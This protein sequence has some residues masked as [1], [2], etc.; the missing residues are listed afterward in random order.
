MDTDLFLQR[1]RDLPLEEGKALV[2]EYVQ[3]PQD[4]QA[5]GALLGSDALKQLYT[6][7][8]ISLKLAE[9]LVH[10]GDMVG[11]VKIHA[12]GL[13]AR[14]DALRAVGLHAVSMDALD[15]A[16]AEFLSVGDEI[17]WARSRISWI[18]SCAWLGRF[19]EA[20]LEAR[21]AHDVL[22]RLG[23]RYWACVID[24]NT[25][26]ILNYAGRYQE[27]IDLYDRMLSIYPTMTDQSEGTLKRAI[28]MAKISKG[29]VISLT[30][31]F[32]EAYS[33]IEEALATFLDL[34]ETNLAISS[35]S[36]LA[37]IDYAQGYFGSALQRYYQARDSMVEHK[38]GDPWL[39]SILRLNIARCL[40]KLNRAP[41]ACQLAAEVV[42][43]YRQ[44]GVSLDTG[45]ALR[46]YAAMLAAA[47]RMKEAIGVLDEAWMLFASGGFTYHAAITS[48]QQSEL[49][50]K[51]GAL[52][53]AY[54][55]AQA[56]RDYCSTQ[57]LIARAVAASLVMIEAL[58]EKARPAGIS[59]EAQQGYVQQALWLCRQTVLQARQHN[60]QEEVYKTRHLMGRLYALQAMPGR[61]AQQYRSAIRQIERM[62]DNLVSDLSP[63]FLH[64]TWIV[65][66]EMIA[67]SLQR[68]R[69]EEAFN[70]LERARSIAL[71]Q[72]L[73]RSKS[74]QGISTDR[75]SQPH[76]SR[77]AG[78]SAAILRAQ[79]ELDEWQRKYRSYSKLLA[80]TDTM[81]AQS[82]NRHEAEIELE[83]CEAKV[84]E[85]F[86][87]LHLYQSGSTIQRRTSKGQHRDAMPANTTWLRQ[88]LASGQLLL[89]YFI[90]KEKV[91]IFA[92]TAEQLVTREIPG[93]VEQLEQLLQ[94]LYARL[95]P[96]SVSSQQ[97]QA[98]RRLLHKLYDLLIAPVA[99]ML[100][101]SGGSITIV[102]YEQLH[103]F[104]FHALYDGSRF[105]VERFQI[106]YLPASNILT[107]GNDDHK[108]GQ[109]HR[110]QTPVKPLILGYSG[111]R[112][113]Q[114][115]LEEA[116]TLAT[117]LDGQCYLENEATI[118]RLI[119][120]APGSPIIHL[121]THGQM[122]L[123][124][125]NFSSAL[126]ADG[127]LN[128][129]DAF[130]LD[131]KECELVTLSGCETGLAVTSGG[132]EQLGLGRAF[133]A[134]GAASIVMSLWPVEDNATNEL[135]QLF[136]S[137]L[138]QGE[139][140]VQ[141]LRMAQL[142]LLTRTPSLYTHPY[143]WA[144]FRLV[145][146]ASPLKF[147]VADPV[148]VPVKLMR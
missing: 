50:L 127:Q 82:L 109:T 38:I 64:T 126:L 112:S 120:Q 15:A 43:V 116:K 110:D 30:G 133:L 143:F 31:K 19:D 18:V 58:I 39:L 129:I 132:D 97:E 94:F 71:R 12:N 78:E 79:Q 77:S 54:D 1:L 117:M 22:E 21:R 24:H 42:E 95:L 100:P 141:A 122:R 7:P 9:H 104:P 123:D 93:G 45:D 146:D 73:S 51:T 10:L 76:R 53:A 121:A 16:G 111:N 29:R 23:E 55:K 130:S 20:L 70:Y 131:L 3:E 62:L 56:M 119:E 47:Q 63:S 60:L 108:N 49:L 107:H 136:Y 57:G 69:P 134:A 147:R 17:N 128:A 61:A 27:A 33:L 25:A 46:E 80:E 86:E 35:Q 4:F 103:K 44:Q 8:A 26:V 85:L 137:N 113:L 74:L 32:D 148:V 67:L 48:I 13:K 138:L 6:D 139:S 96:A 37:N 40:V 66:E 101:P 36:N 68:S 118:A 88:N 34:A 11:D 142:S 135:M 87:R 124:A 105:L 92:A 91:V 83:L 72:Y 89:A 90:A 115:A 81:I 99:S 98:V 144:S 84:S 125:P 59:R 145:G 102:P 140:K 65:Y 106:N 75:R 28:A 114:R 52:D 41:E 5:F 2:Q 14:G